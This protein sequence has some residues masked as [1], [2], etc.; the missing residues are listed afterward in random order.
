M[1]LLD[2]SSNDI[3]TNDILTAIQNLK[4]SNQAL[5]ASNEEL[6]T[7]VSDLEET[8]KGM[9]NN[10]VGTINALNKIY[11]VGSIYIS[12]TLKVSQ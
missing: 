6:T 1:L 4:N 8:I 9:N 11:P 10:G 12:T 5:I 7:K 3:G 2:S